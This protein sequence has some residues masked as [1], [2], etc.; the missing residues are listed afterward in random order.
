MLTC[1][2]CTFFFIQ[3]FIKTTN[4]FMGEGVGL[5]TPNNFKWSSENHWH[6]ME[7]LMPNSLLSIDLACYNLAHH[8][9]SMPL[10]TWLLH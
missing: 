5:T 6:F 8:L 3:L 1:L 7:A 2:Q 9:N 10:M 4:M